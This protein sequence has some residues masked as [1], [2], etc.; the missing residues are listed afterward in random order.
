MATEVGSAYISLWPNFQGFGAKLQSGFAGEISKV[1][2][3]I[4]GDLG[5]AFD[6][7]A[8]HAAD[9]AKRVGDEV[10]KHT[11]RG[12][13]E[14]S[15]SIA[16]LGVSIAAVATIAAGVGQALNKG[17]QS[18]RLEA[19]LGLSPADAKKAADASAA[20]YGQAW[21]DSLEDVN[22]A[23]KAVATNLAGVGGDENLQGL[24]IQALAFKSAFGED[25]PRIIN[26][27]TQ[28]LRTG[29]VSSEQEAFDLLAVGFQNGTNKADD[30]LDT[31]NEYSTQFRKLGL[32]GVTALGLVSQAVNAGA[33]DSDVAADAL[34]EF[35]IRSID[36][37]K[38]TG[39]AFHDLGL[40]ADK[41]A[42]QI[43][44]GG[45][46]AEA[47][48]GTVLTKLREV[49][50]PVKQ[51]SI[52]VGLFGTQ[53]EDLGAALFAMDPA[54]AKAANGLNNVEGA[55]LRVTDA[56]GR[57][58]SPLETFKRQGMD[59]VA[60]AAEGAVPWLTKV[61]EVVQPYQSEI[62]K[63]ALALGALVIGMKAFAAVQSVVTMLRLAAAAQWLWTGA[64]TAFTFASSLANIQIAL[65]LFWC[66]VVSVATKVWAGVQ[67]LLNVA[68]SAN[69]IGLIVIAI[70]ALVGG[71]IYAWTHFEGFRKVVLAVWDGIKTAAM[72]AWENGL[73]PVMG[74]IVTAA[75]WVGEKAMW[76]WNNVFQPVW[77]GIAA[78][79]NWAWNNVLLPIWQSFQF[80]MGVVGAVTGWLYDN[81]IQPIWQ[82]IQIS[83]SV[84]WAI[85]Q[86]IFGLMQ[87]SMK[88]TGA[89]FI[90][91]YENVVKP[92][93]AAIQAAIGYAWAYIQAVWKALVAAAQWVG[94][95]F[96]WLNVNI[97]Q[98][99]W[100]AIV[101]AISSAWGFIRTIWQG[102][103]AG[104]QWVGG[105]FSWLYNNAIKPAWDA[106][107]SA[108]SAVW[109][110]VIKPVFEAFGSIIRDKVA[111]AFSAGVQAI[112]RA[113]DAVKEAAKAPIRFVVETVINKGIIDNYNKL[114]KTF[115]VD[116][117]D[118]VGLP[119]GFASG[120][121]VWGAGTT[122]S[123]SIP[124]MLSRDEHVWTANEVRGAGG[125]GN[126]IALRE[127]AKQGLIPGFADGGI[128][129]W[130]KDPVGTAK[131]KIGGTLGRL[132]EIENSSFG[133][134]VAGLPRR[135]MDWVVNKVKS[136]VGAFG[137]SGGGFGSWP[138]GPGAQR[139]DSGVWRSIV[140]LINSTGPLSGSFSN[141]YRDGDPLWHG[142]GRAVDWA[143]Y[144]QDALATFLSL[145]NP[146]ELIHRTNSRDYAY[147]R[148]K[149]MGSFDNQLME[150]HRNHIHI[151]MDRGGLLTQGTHLVTHKP[152][153]PDRVLT[154]DQWRIAERAMFGPDGRAAGTTITVPVYPRADHSETEIAHQVAG[155]LGWLMRT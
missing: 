109:N 82:R 39:N 24:T 15:G 88:I 129:D 92:V 35:S 89:V 42:A 122:T 123:D 30:F 114:A 144:N 126:V 99:V 81:I 27:V 3:Q 124:A 69:P 108:I 38:K 111:P 118:H 11:K 46:A 130:I 79:V 73:K 98:P 104:A 33:R 71:V 74:G 134:L 152:R 34:K 4:T 140:A 91:L 149:N 18:A 141:A 25:V 23:V 12:A 101:A 2:K 154:G 51:A 22:V 90:W 16:D 143:G 37:S 21:G 77:A 96:T 103:V 7:A 106:I 19:S 32:D 50:D 86:V 40:D 10:A 44:K 95:I 93:W 125:H 116:T 97:V 80:W 13:K 102:I 58:T 147:T 47:G 54:T 136:V 83:I 72:W 55:G 131:S 26:S 151:A 100:Q 146:L 113:W 41:M 110:G 105:I 53:A 43:A 28:L 133:R 59:A 65:Y 148:G 14:A 45:P 56:M 64:M 20:I 63:A 68:L 142:S 153:E 117:V 5:V 36:G 94:G 66:N 31:I 76:L 48:L 115:K 57:A 137:R 138:S 87:I 121:K 84:A 75:Q 155:E 145:R 49:K 107:S 85:I 119:A 112:A 132:S 52:A 8:D 17:L 78:V 62:G 127:M 139:G 61:L 1:A 128:V 70:A 120:G 9:S 150:E 60:G 135:V 67:W 6:K 29:L